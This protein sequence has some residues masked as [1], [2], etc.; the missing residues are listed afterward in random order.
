[1][2]P[3]RTLLF[4]PGNRERMLEKAPTLGADAILADLED[5]VPEQEKE[6]G[7]RMIADWLRASPG[8]DVLVRVNALDTGHTRA[9]LDAIVTPGLAGILLP[10]ASDPAEVAHVAGWLDEL[11]A[12][13]GVAAGGIEIVVMVE[14]A[15]A[16]RRS[17]ELACAPRVASLCFGGAENGDL[18]TDL[19]AEWS[20][21]GT[22]LL[23][24]R[25][26]VLLEGRAAGIAH[27]LDG[28]FARLDDEAALIADT[29]LSKRLGY[30]GRTVIHPKQVEPVRAVYSPTEEELDRW[31][32]LLAAFD[33]AIADGRATATFEGAMIDYAMAAR[34]RSVLALSEQLA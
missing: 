9:D 1:V 10:K 32:R 34:A 33:A 19:G 8:C 11:E 27:P 30:K 28:V 20:A 3:Y 16:V 26:R 6:N 25:S 12:A 21:E 7:R 2:K 17:Y 23:Y 22:E 24:A 18:Q 15:L 29:R 31:R 14:S 4:V 13:A 5:G